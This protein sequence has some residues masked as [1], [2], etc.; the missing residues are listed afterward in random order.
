[1][2][3][4]SAL[5]PK[6]DF[7]RLARPYRWLEYATFGPFLWRCRIRYLAEMRTC[8]SA[9]VLGD[10]DGRFT[11][12]LL[13][14]NSKIR[15]HAVDGSRGMIGTLENAAK[16]NASRLTAEVADLRT[17]SPGHAASY[18]LIVSHFFLDC[19]TSGEVAGLALRVAAA[20][21]PGARWAVSDFVVPST[22]FG[23]LVAR[24]IVAALYAIFGWLTHLRVRSLPDHGE[25]LAAAGW[26]LQAEHV[27]LRGLLTSQLW[28][29]PTISAPNPSELQ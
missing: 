1:M 3:P 19:L 9:L 8:S 6:P 26:S 10:G 12:K 28:L 18:D 29:R 20:A 5:G 13:R 22:R 24:P 23:S 4:V 25:G 2:K 17:W 27:Q 7:D 11:A 21:T 15:V 14:E 16:A